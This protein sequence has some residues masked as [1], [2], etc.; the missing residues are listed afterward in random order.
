[1]DLYSYLVL[2]VGIVAYFLALR[3][4]KL[5]PKNMEILL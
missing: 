2:D 1:M 3:E 4:I 5:G